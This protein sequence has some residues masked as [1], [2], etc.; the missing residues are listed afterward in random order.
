MNNVIFACLKHRKMIA[1]KLQKVIQG[2]LFAGKAI[3]VVGARQV[4]KSTLFRTILADSD[5]RILTINGDE[6]EAKELLSGMN[7]QELGMLVGNNEIVLIDEAQKIPG[8][9]TTLKLITDNF[10]GVQLL[11]TG[12]SSFDLQDKLNEP[13]TGRKLEYHLYPISTAEILDTSGLLGVKQSLESRLIYGSYPDVLTHADSAK[14]LLM[15]LS[16]S[17][18]YRDLLPMEGVRRPILLEK[19]LTAL[20]LQIS[21]EVSYNELAQTVGADSKT[22]EKYIGLLEKCYIIFHLSGFS[23]NLRSELKKSKKIYF[24]DNGV[25]NAI[26][27]NFAPLPLRGDV[28]ALWENFIISERIK[29]NHYAGRYTNSYFWRTVAQ[30]EID[31]I[32]ESDGAFSLFEMKWNPKKSGS[33]FPSAFLNAYNVKEKTVVTPENYLNVLI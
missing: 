16:G 9:G 8:I 1:R 19:L 31:Y 7:T 30:Q 32:E 21:N 11:I 24:F 33:S 17:Y 28:G 4:G 22:V 13:L 14:E 10:P 15:N 6:P 29:A 20:A 18:L 2:R 26:L 12:S 23:R 27:Q 3:V 5:R 25:R